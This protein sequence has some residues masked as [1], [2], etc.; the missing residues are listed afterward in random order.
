MKD[1]GTEGKIKRDRM[2]DKERLIERKC[3]SEIK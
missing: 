2:Q 1:K 3:E